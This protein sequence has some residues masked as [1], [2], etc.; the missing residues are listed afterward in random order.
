M[1]GL[2]REELQL[3][4]TGQ[5]ALD[6]IDK[7]I[8][9]YMGS[10][11][12]KEN[13]LDI[14]ATDLANVEMP[15]Y[16]KGKSAGFNINRKRFNS[17]ILNAYFYT[18]D[19]QSTLNP[20][21]KEY[22]LF[23]DILDAYEYYWHHP[24]SSVSNKKGMFQVYQFLLTWL[25]S[26]DPIQGDEKQALYLLQSIYIVLLV[27][28]LNAS[29]LS[30]LL[31]SFIPTEMN[32]LTLKVEE[33]IIEQYNAIQSS[34][35]QNNFEIDTNKSAKDNVGSAI[36][37]IFSTIKLKNKKHLQNI[38]LMKETVDTISGVLYQVQNL[39]SNFWDIF[40]DENDFNNFLSLL[41]LDEKESTHWKNRYIKEQRNKKKSFFDWGGGK[42]K[43]SHFTDEF[44][45]NTLNSAIV[46]YCN[47]LFP[48]E[49]SSCSSANANDRAASLLQK[50]EKQY[51]PLRFLSAQSM[52]S[53]YISKLPSPYICSLTSIEQAEEEV[54]TFESQIEATFQQKKYL[55]TH[56]RS[57]LSDLKIQIENI[58]SDLKVAHQTCSKILEQLTPFV[59]EQEMYV[60]QEAMCNYASAFDVKAQQQ[61]TVTRDYH[62]VFI[63][64]ETKYESVLNTTQ[65]YLS[66]L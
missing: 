25:E 64:I 48:K 42:K 65:H 45:V 39:K 46:S 51:A 20:L 63:A 18:Q 29:E 36:E 33:K 23:E 41:S 62:S 9:G 5:L 49:F 26:K 28:K 32:A 21:N 17:V 7:V 8:S 66:T 34:I 57:N 58:L 40:F 31:K 55:Y 43:S 30:P 19:Y 35:Q 24:L 10:L 1:T 61:D 44:I 3:E 15:L 14:I 11:K 52:C 50:L 38:S 16:S 56:A 54:T 37:I 27:A 2:N 53:D 13:A 60:L 4:P 12:S 47:K 59:S 22:K 6:T